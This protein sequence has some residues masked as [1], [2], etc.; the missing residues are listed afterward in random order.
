MIKLTR[1]IALITAVSDLSMFFDMLN[2]VAWEFAKINSRS[3]GEKSP[4]GPTNR[5]KDLQSFNSL[6]WRL[7]FEFTSANKSLVEP[8]RFFKK[9]LSLI[10]FKT[11]GGIN[12]F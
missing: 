12:W 6:A 5:H 11:S 1:E 7:S 4:S 10:T 8:S 3:G 2:E 9:S